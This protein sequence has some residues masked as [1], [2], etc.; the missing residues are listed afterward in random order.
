MVVD[1]AAREE[2]SLGD[3]GV[4][5]PVGDEREDVELSG[6][7]PARRSSASSAADRAGRRDHRVAAGGEPRRTPLPVRRASPVWRATLGGLPRSRRPPE[8]VPPRTAGRAPTMTRPPAAASPASSSAYGPVPDV[9]GAARRC[10]PVVATPGAR[11]RHVER[12]GASCEVERAVG[13]GARC[14]GVSSEPGGLRARDGDRGDP[15]QLARR[16]GQRARPVEQRRD[17]R[18]GSARAD[19]REHRQG[20]RRGERRDR[21]SSED[22]AGGRRRLGP[23][24]LCELVWRRGRRSR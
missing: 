15:V 18:I 10:P 9:T 14:R 3:L 8:P 4:A 16:V 24:A 12:F 7:E 6:G 19:A 23:E 17:V 11:R 21:A 2:Q 5:K 20:Q 22:G 1:R 13:R